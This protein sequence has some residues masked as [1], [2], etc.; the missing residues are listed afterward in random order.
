MTVAVVVTGGDTRKAKN[1]TLTVNV[2]HLVVYQI[3]GFVER[4]EDG[5]AGKNRR[6]PCGRVVCQI[7]VHPPDEVAMSGGAGAPCGRS[8]PMQHSC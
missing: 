2:I 3:H 6:V 1:K 8:A 5:P 4:G 7:P